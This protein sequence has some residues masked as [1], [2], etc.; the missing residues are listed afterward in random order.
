MNTTDIVVAGA[1]GCALALLALVWYGCRL[2]AWLRE[3]F[4]FLVDRRMM[5][6]LVHRRVFKYETR[7]RRRY[8]RFIP[9]SAYQIGESEVLLVEGPRHVVFIHPFSRPFRCCVKQRLLVFH[10]LSGDV[11][12]K[13]YFTYEQ[14]IPAKA[15]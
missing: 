1:L 15:R 13:I 12:L 11:R 14:N 5:C 4:I 6:S 8:A 3:N 7:L 9:S 2:C 10:D